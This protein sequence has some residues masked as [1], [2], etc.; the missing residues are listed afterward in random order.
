M[1]LKSFSSSELVSLKEDE[2][3]VMIHGGWVGVAQTLPSLVR[4][5]R[6]R[7]KNNNNTLTPGSR[8]MRFGVRCDRIYSVET[9]REYPNFYTLY[10]FLD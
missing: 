2:G 6:F 7:N 9:K 4:G 8:L 3:M 1:Y 10:F 5:E